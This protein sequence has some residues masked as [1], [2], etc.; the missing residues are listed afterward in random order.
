MSFNLG[1]K[2]LLKGIRKN[3]TIKKFNISYNAISHHEIGKRLRTVLAK[4]ETLEYLN[5][6]GNR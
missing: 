1:I 6:S 5:I 2:E 3:I 4:T